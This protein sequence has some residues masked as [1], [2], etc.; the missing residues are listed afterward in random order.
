MVAYGGANQRNHPWEKPAELNANPW[1]LQS[2]AMA[3]G[4]LEVISDL[5]VQTYS[6]DL[7]K[8]V[9]CKRNKECMVQANFMQFV[10]KQSAKNTQQS[11]HKYM[12]MVTTVYSR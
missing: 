11:V 12:H 5:S 1:G 4:D 3:M 8:Q 2:P 7:Y 9:G 10:T 6:C